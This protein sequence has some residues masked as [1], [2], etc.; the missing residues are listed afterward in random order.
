MR[1]LPS[2]EEIRA[3]EIRDMINAGGVYEMPMQIIH[4]FT[5]DICFDR[6]EFRPF[7]FI[8]TEPMPIPSI[9]IDWRM[10]DG[11]LVCPNHEVKSV[12]FIDGKEVIT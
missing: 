2:T 7:N 9:P 10:V 11:L 12:V 6:I 1:N 4:K 5:C 8:P 3:A